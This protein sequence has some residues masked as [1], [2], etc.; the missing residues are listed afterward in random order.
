MARP[1]SALSPPVQEGADADEDL[2]EER[3]GPPDEVGG[4]GHVLVGAVADQQGH[5][6]GVD[7]AEAARGDRDEPGEPGQGEGGEHLR[8]V[9]AGGVAADGVERDQQDQEL[10]GLLGDAGERDPT[11]PVAHQVVQ[12]VAE[13]HQGVGDSG[14]GAGAARRALAEPVGEPGDETVT[15]ATQAPGRGLTAQDEGEPT[16]HHH[17]HHHT[18]HGAHHLV[19]LHLALEQQQHH[20]EHRQGQGD[21]QVPGAGGADGRRGGCGAVAVV[22][23][24]GVLHPDAE[25]SAGG[26]HVGDH[27]RG[28]AHHE[29]RPVAQSRQRRLVGQHVHAH[30]EHG[31]AQQQRD[32]GQ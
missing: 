12:L 13:A 21:H 20:G 6:G 2:R 28:L 4:E 19:G 24:H 10:A 29:R 5:Q 9:D 23:E 3:G 32:R 18:H 22:A 30:V 8:R 16:D 25:R 27:E 17:H 14:G 7:G 15:Q 26:D 1:P 11:P 31:D